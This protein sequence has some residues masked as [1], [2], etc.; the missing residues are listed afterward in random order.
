MATRSNLFFQWKQDFNIAEL[1]RFNPTFFLNSNNKIQKNLLVLGEI[2]RISTPTFEAL[3]SF[4]KN[5]E[6]WLFGYISYDAK[7][8]LEKL[9]SKNESSHQMKDLDF[10][11]P[12]LVFEWT[13]IEGCA[14]YFPELTSKER[15]LEIIDQ[16]S[17]SKEPIKEK[18]KIEF[19]PRINRNDYLKKIEKLKKEIQ[20]GNIYEINFCQEFFANETIDPY[21]TYEHL[22]SISPTPYSCFVHINDHYLMCASPEQYLEKKGDKIISKPIKGTIKRSSNKEEDELFK[23]KLFH[24]E[25]DRAENVMIVDLVRNDLS[26]CAKKRSIK[27]DELF[28]I[29]SFPQVHQMISTISMKLANKF[30]GID[31]IKSSFPMGSMTGAPKL[32]AME[33]IE[34]E[35]SFKRNLYSGS[36][37]Y[38]APNSDFC[39]N[40]VI[41]SL[42]Y[43]PQESMLSFAV[44]G[45]ITDGSI[46][47]DEYNESMLKAKAIFEIFK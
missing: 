31:V 46:P 41:R 17:Q 29:Y 6:D 25:K 42:F 13:G 9:E 4:Q 28:G 26:K 47:L 34:K 10:I 38:F 40:V 22:N 19:E 36:V 16:L 3:E 37:G 45:A 18:I 8:Q 21:L 35:E 44:G 2:N 7:N 15:V 1:N 32:K 23:S 39:F 12:E 30:S 11:I 33:I 5:H 24:S 27:V 43:S 20:Y 14:H